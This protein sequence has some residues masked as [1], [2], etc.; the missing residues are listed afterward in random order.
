MPTPSPTSTLPNIR[1]IIVGAQAITIAPIV[2]KTSANIINFLRPH[3]SEAVPE[4]KD[5]TAAPS[6]ARL[7]ISDL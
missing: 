4:N 5:P 1:T 3:L 6:K 7:T 2:N